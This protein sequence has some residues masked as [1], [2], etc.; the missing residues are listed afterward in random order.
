MNER[1]R[2]SAAE[3][4]AEGDFTYIVCDAAGVGKPDLAAN[5]PLLA[6]GIQ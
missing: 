3:A 5:I 6:Q 1:A 2:D 4:E